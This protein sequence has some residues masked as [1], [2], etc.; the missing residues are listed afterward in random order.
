MCGGA[1]VERNEVGF[2]AVTEYGAF[3][4]HSRLNNQ[5][6]SWP[7]VTGYNAGGGVFA[8]ERFSHYKNK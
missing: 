8:D 6:L 5:F 7:Y 4:C 1:G 2:H 3:P